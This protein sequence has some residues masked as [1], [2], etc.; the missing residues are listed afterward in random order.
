MTSLWGEVAMMRAP[1]INVPDDPKTAPDQNSVEA[2]QVTDTVNRSFA[3]EVVDAHRLPAHLSRC[4]AA[5]AG[6]TPGR[7][8]K[9]PSPGPSSPDSGR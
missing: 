3:Q 9:G 5:K 1:M 4:A 2:R 6:F 7:T 8:R